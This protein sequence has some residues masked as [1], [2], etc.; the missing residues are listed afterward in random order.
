MAYINYVLFIVFLL[1]VWFIP[2][3]SFYLLH[4]P[5]EKEYVLQVNGIEFL[6]LILL[7]TGVVALGAPGFLDLMA[8]RLLVLEVIVT[9]IL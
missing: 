9:G 4:N 3:G 8:L 6:W 1:L 5:L 2:K 7:A